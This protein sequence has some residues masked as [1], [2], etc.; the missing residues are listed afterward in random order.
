MPDTKKQ[1]QRIIQDLRKMVGFFW[2]FFKVG[3]FTFGG[4]Y[5]I[6]PVIQKKMVEEKEWLTEDTF[7]DLMAVSQSV[8]GALAINMSFQV[9]HKI[10]GPVG[11]ICALLGTAL[12]SFLVILTIS[13]YFVEFL[14]HPLVNAFFKGVLPA[15]V[16]LI[17][18]AAWKL[19]KNTVTGK[20]QAALLVLLLLGGY[21]LSMHPFMVIF[22]GALGG[23]LLFQCFPQNEGGAG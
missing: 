23:L 1:R 7:T 10:Y 21:G 13:V 15:I 5:V 8:P 17:V 4:G 11:A 19:G 16:A 22:A 2:L 18:S 6:L 12:P 14:D 20:K 9:G 3:L